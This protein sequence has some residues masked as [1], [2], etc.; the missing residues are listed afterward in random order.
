MDLC[1]ISSRTDGRFDNFLALKISPDVYST[2]RGLFFLLS[3]IYGLV[4][5]EFQIGRASC[6]ERV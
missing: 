6:R 2:S 5:I 1:R 4:Q 3:I